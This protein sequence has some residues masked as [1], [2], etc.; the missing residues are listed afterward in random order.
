LKTLLLMRHAKSSWADDEIPDHDRPLNA[1]G[2]R[3]APAMGALLRAQ[4]LEPDAIL[5]STARRARDTA[6]ALARALEWTPEITLTREL[7]LAEP[8]VIL[9]CIA[10]TPSAVDRLLVVGHN[11]GVEDLLD[12][13]CHHHEHMPTAA[14]AKLVFD[15]PEWTHVAQA[16]ATLDQVWRPKEIA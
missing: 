8:N 5:S 11:P 10:K 1:R 14:I 16:A 6:F 13:L 12:D 4:D 2:E 3:D 15:V 9:A 7:Y